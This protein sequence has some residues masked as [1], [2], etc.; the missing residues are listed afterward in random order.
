MQS[1]NYLYVIYKHTYKQDHKTMHPKLIKQKIKEVRN[2]CIKN[3]WQSF[4]FYKNQKP[5]GRKSFIEE[6]KS[7]RDKKKMYI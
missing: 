6:G 5:K 7:L 4:F 3:E 1:V 2:N